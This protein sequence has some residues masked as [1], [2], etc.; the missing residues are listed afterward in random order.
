MIEEDT[1]A[2]RP[3]LQDVANTVTHLYELVKYFKRNNL[4]TWPN[5]WNNNG[6][7]STV[8]ELKNA[9]FEWTVEKLYGEGRDTA[10]TLAAQLTL[11]NH[12]EL[13]PRIKAYIEKLESYKD[14]IPTDKQL[15]EDCR[16]FLHKELR[17]AGIDYRAIEQMIEL[18]EE[19][20]GV[21]SDL[22]GDI[23][24]LKHSKR[25]LTETGLVVSCAPQP[26]ASVFII[27]GHDEARWRELEKI[28]RDDFRLKPVVLG[29]MADGGAPTLVEK[30]EKYA[31]ACSYAIAIFTPDDQVTNDRETYLQVRPNVLFELGWFCA[32]LGRGKV[33]ILR[34]RDTNDRAFSDFGGVMQKRFTPTISECFKDIETELKEAKLFTV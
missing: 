19:Q 2:I 26:T 30:F 5:L 22:D 9:E 16:T 6:L 27:H 23:R 17:Q 31:P 28:I 20:L 14:W 25:Y 8:H 15:I 32:Y 10:V 1:I 12:V 4:E 21:I 11:I 7:S 24:A 3:D 13:C 18:H 29:E 34:Q 33:M